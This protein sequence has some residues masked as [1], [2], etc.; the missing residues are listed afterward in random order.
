MTTFYAAVCESQSENLIKIVVKVVVLLILYLR[1]VNYVRVSTCIKM[2][3]KLRYEHCACL[4]VFIII[5]FWQF[6]TGFLYL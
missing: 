1:L 6:I 2:N 3:S 4:I 5:N